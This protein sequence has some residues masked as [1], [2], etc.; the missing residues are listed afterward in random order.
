MSS[1]AWPEPPPRAILF[2]WDNTLVDN[3]ASVLSAFNATLVAFGREPWT[4]AQSRARI[5]N[6]LRDSFP[7]LF[8]ARWTE[9]RD[10]FYRHYRAEHLATLQPLAGAEATLGA[11]HAAGVYLGVVSNK[12]GFLLRAEAEHLGWSRLFGRLVGAGDA[13]ADKP[14][15]AAVALALAGSGIAAGPQVWL[16]GDDRIDAECALA[17]GCR[18][19]L[20][21]DAAAPRAVEAPAPLRLADCRELLAVLGLAEMS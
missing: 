15:P 20:V 6:S 5:R 8:G 9:A 14:S 1:P 13:E 11:L 21:G 16:V 12:T 10:L 7:G 3:W 19:V 17:A 18:P 4:H 2:D